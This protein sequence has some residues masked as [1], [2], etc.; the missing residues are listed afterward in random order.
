MIESLWKIC[1]FSGPIPAMRK[2]SENF[3]HIFSMHPWL[4]NFC[5]ATGLG[6]INHL[7]CSWTR[8]HPYKWD[9][10]HLNRRGTR[11][12][13]TDITYSLQ[14][15]WPIGRIR[16]NSYS[17][18]P[19]D[20]YN[21]FKPQLTPYRYSQVW[22]PLLIILTLMVNQKDQFCYQSLLLLNLQVSPCLLI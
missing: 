8:E 11:L 3:S 5:V 9:N 13:I 2:S 6:F 21:I 18:F 10:L 14:V 15:S 12:L 19:P 1:F 20:I 4:D 7:N 22:D 16:H 17:H